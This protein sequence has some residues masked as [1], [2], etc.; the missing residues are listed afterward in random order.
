MHHILLH[1]DIIRDLASTL[2]SKTSRTDPFA[3]F[4]RLVFGNSNSAILC[5]YCCCCASA[6][7]ASGLTGTGAGFGGMVVSVVEG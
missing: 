7:L 3:S 6:S 4:T 1:L 2:N 5:E